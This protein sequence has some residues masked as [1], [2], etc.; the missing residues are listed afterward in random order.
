MV[1]SPHKHHSIVNSLRQSGHQYSGEIKLT[2]KNPNGKTSLKN[3]DKNGA[4]II[5]VNSS[6]ILPSGE[7]PDRSAQAS[8][9]NGAGNRQDAMNKQLDEFLRN[10]ATEM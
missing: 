5:G 2:N 8:P 3:L 6:M 9:S 4:A 10:D 1:Q 7:S